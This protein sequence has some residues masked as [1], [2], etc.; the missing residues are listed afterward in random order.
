MTPAQRSVMEPPYNLRMNRQSLDSTTGEVHAHYL[1][2]QMDMFCCVLMGVNFICVSFMVKVIEA[3]PR[4]G[5][6]VEFDEKV[7]GS[8]YY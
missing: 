6:K 8:K 5:F 2:L 3:A 4:E 1:S 7:F